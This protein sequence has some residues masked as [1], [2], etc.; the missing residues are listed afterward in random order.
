M[1]P[2]KVKTGTSRTVPVAAFEEVEYFIPWR[3]PLEV[4]GKINPLSGIHI[5]AFSRRDVFGPDKLK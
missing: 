4:N 3:Y 2:P 5:L 1:N